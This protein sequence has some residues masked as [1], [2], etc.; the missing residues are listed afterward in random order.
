[1]T[2]IVN[3]EVQNI[4]QATEYTFTVQGKAHFIWEFDTEQ[5]KSDFV[6][7]DK[8]ILD[9]PLQKGILESHPGIDRLEVN[10][11]PFWKKSFPASKDNILII[12]EL[13]D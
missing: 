7:K 5:L 4:W 13:D 1:M 6:S 11:R 10:I 9:T 8:A 2:P 3:D 12:T